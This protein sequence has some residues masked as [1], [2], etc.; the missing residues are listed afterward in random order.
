MVAWVSYRIARV[1]MVAWVSYR[2]ARGGYGNMGVL[3]NSIG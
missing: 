3:W 2:I 1:D